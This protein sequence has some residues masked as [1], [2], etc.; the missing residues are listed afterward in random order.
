MRKTRDAVLGD[1]ARRAPFYTP[2]W[3]FNPAL[4]DAR[5]ELAMLWADMFAGTLERFE[6]LP[7]DYRRSL[8]NAIDPGPRPAEPARGCLSFSLRDDASEIVIPAGTEISSPSNSAAVLVTD[9]GITASPAKVTDIYCVIPARN[10]VFRHDGVVDLELFRVPDGGTHIW[11]FSHPYAFEVSKGAVLRLFP[12]LENGELD[13]L[14]ILPWEYLDGAVWREMKVVRDGG[15]LLCSFS[16]DKENIC[17]SIRLSVR[18][19]SDDNLDSASLLAFTA[20]PSSRGLSAGELYI[21][22]AQDDDNDSYLFGRRFSPGS[23][24]YFSCSDA[25]TKPGARVEL[26]FTLSYDNFEIEGYPVHLKNFLRVS[27]FDQPEEFEITAARVEWEYWNGVYWA[28]LGIENG[29]GVFD[30]A[31]SGHVKLVFDCPADLQTVVVGERELPFIRARLITADNLFRRR[32]HYRAPRVS[33]TRFGY[34]YE[35]G[36]AITSARVSGHLDT[37]ETELPARLTPLPDGPAAI[38]FAFNKPF[39]QCS[40]LFEIAPGARMSRLRWE[41]LTVS[42]WMSPDVNDE[43]KGLTET[44]ILTCKTAAS[45]VLN[46]LW[47]RDAYWIRLAAAG[48]DYGGDPLRRPRLTRLYENAVRATMS[49]SGGTSALPADSFTA[50]TVPIAGVES[51]TNPFET[52]GGANVESEEEVVARLTAGLSHQGRAVSAGD[53]EA[54]ALEASRHV[55]RARCYTNTDENGRDAYGESCLVLLPR[56]A[57][58]GGFELL[59]GEVSSYIASRRA[60]GSGPLHIVQPAYVAVNVSVYT[61]DH[62]PDVTLSAEHRIAEVLERLLSPVHWEI[63]RLPSPELIEAAIRAVEGAGDLTEIRTSYVRNGVVFDYARIISEPFVFPVSGSH[64]IMA[65]SFR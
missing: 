5:A 25:L 27:D 11:T 14:A 22:S 43:T 26:S 44:G 40:L 65:S 6:R 49:P 55:L 48:D 33:D 1:I 13:D 20:H 12:G 56:G 50:M 61:A 4:P 24:A 54:L 38:Y 23:C 42:G 39:T 15:S 60:L 45:A 7:D 16:E 2:E 35:K 59:R 21:D 36:I 58:F 46:R 8:F 32:G 62:N 52:Y 3:R 29:N 28:P 17:T 37:C 63:G 18:S 47:G 19:M 9:S 41:Y 53:C 31:A 30:G 57:A 64:K 51:V 34:R 10:A